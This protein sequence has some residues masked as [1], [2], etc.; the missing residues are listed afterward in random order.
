MF[1]SSA[2]EAERHRR[3][4]ARRSTQQD[5]FRARQVGRR[6]GSGEGSRDTGERCDTIR[7]SQERRTR[8]NKHA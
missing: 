1:C 4:A 2:A 8:K 3:E 5:W 7:R 6:R